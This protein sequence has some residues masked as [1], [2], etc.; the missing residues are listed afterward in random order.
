MCQAPVAPE[1]LQSPSVQDLTGNCRLAAQHQA[2]STVSA[3]AKLVHE[4][5]GHPTGARQLPQALLPQDQRLSATAVKAC[6]LESAA[7]CS[8]GSKQAAAEAATAG[9]AAWPLQSSA[10]DSQGSWGATA[11][12]ALQRLPSQWQLA[13]D[14]AGRQGPACLNSGHTSGGSQPSW[15][16]ASS[17][18]AASTRLEA[19]EPWQGCLAAR[20]HH[21]GPASH[22][23]QALQGESGAQHRNQTV[24]LSNL[25]NSTSTAV[26]LLSTQQSRHPLF[27][28]LSLDGAPQQEPASQ[29]DAGQRNSACR[30]MSWR[31][32]QSSVRP[33]EGATDSS[34]RSLAQHDSGFEQAACSS[35]DY[36]SSRFVQP[37]EGKSVC[38]VQMS[39]VTSQASTHAGAVACRVPRCYLERQ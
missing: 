29:Q 13:A 32:T 8:A 17:T 20:Q 31:E 11:A 12:A 35:E 5:V 24:P 3:P 10:A 23:A 28:N 27:T 14:A 22:G 37:S 36:S 33:A 19:A 18:C 25:L 21:A 39:A 6:W 1:G 9:G 15:C 4:Q 34:S 38:C 26:D 2:R 7:G 16:Q 30:H